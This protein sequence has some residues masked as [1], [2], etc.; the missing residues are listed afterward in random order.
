MEDNKYIHQFYNGLDHSWEDLFNSLPQF[1]NGW[2][3]TVFTDITIDLSFYHILWQLIKD[4]KSD[5]LEK[6]AGI[7]EKMNVYEGRDF[8][9]L[10]PEELYKALAVI[11]S[12]AARVLLS[13]FECTDG[14]YN[15]LVNSL[16]MRKQA[17]FIEALINCNTTSITQITQC[18][19]FLQRQEQLFEY[20]KKKA[21]CN[22]PDDT[23]VQCIEDLTADYSL[24]A[25]ELNNHQMQMNFFFN[26]VLESV[27]KLIKEIENKIVLDGTLSGEDNDSFCSYKYFTFFFRYCKLRDNSVL[28]TRATMSFEYLFKLPAV[29]GLYDEGIEC[30]KNN[31][32][33]D[34]L[35]ELKSR[36]Q[37]TTTD[38]GKKTIN[39]IEPPT[40]QIKEP[41]KEEVKV[42]PE[43]SRNAPGQRGRRN[44]RW[45]KGRSQ[46]GEEQIGALIQRD[47]WDSLVKSVNGFTFQDG[48][49]GKTRAT[50]VKNFSA[51]LLYYVLEK[52]GWARVFD[53]DGI[54][55]SF[56]RTMSFAKISR[57]S[58]KIYIDYF[59][60][61]YLAA[62]AIKERKI[63]LQDL[64][65]RCQAENKDMAFLIFNNLS[66][67]ESLIEEYKVKLKKTLD[68]SCKL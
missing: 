3:K 68:E 39:E 11:G 41:D 65:M 67:I 34:K 25:M 56:K 6:I 62:D 43:Q 49:A 31:S 32:W 8:H 26:E 28:N 63:Q 42:V 40:P 21:F 59:H 22:N 17:R 30:W 14:I 20:S 37:D 54:Q 1:P 64:F 38:E 66:K 48:I 7:I 13:R 27:P 10:T 53:E 61:W 36:L 5:V 46:I 29:R 33:E 2:G 52:I 16:S 9:R 4:C 57:S 19:R 18:I 50:K 24:Q 44:D 12:N 23:N 47:I 55:S 45:I 15:E 58:F 60:N 35:S 51:A